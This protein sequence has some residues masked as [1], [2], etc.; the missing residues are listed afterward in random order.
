MFSY[1]Q[2]QH[3]FL[4]RSIHLVGKDHS[5]DPF[6]KM[7]R[8]KIHYGRPGFRNFTNSNQLKFRSGFLTKSMTLIWISKWFLK[9]L[10]QFLKHHIRISITKIECFAPLGRHQ[11]LWIRW[12]HHAPLQ[13][14]HDLTLTYRVFLKRFPCV[15]TQKSQVPQTH[16]WYSAVTKVTVLYVDGIQISGEETLDKNWG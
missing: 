7:S 1:S 8:L 5:I 4:C 6:G 15:E 12:V 10:L 2:C 9:W 16:R 13:V 11:F 3:A 14:E